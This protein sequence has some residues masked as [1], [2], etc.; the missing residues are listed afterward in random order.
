MPKRCVVYGCSNTTDLA[1]GTVLYSIPFFG[2]T[3]P[4]AVERRKKWVDFVRRRRD[5]WSP[6][7]SSV[8]CQKHFTADCFDHGSVAIEKY[9]R[10]R[11]RRDEYGVCVF[12]TLQSGVEEK[13][14]SERTKRKRRREEVS[15]FGRDKLY[16]S[17]YIL[18][19]CSLCLSVIIQSFSVK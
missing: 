14:E 15:V 1:K 5:K 13:E 16:E 2:E 18:Y 17:A 4:V 11:L 9:K 6:T 19:T 12:L 8:L 10:P 3:S 7:N